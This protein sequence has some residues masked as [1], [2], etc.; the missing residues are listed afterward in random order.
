MNRYYVGSSGTVVI[1]DSIIY[2]D[3]VVSMFNLWLISVY[4]DL[5][6]LEWFKSKLILACGFY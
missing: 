3:L 5:E 4:I 1:S 6:I 2:F